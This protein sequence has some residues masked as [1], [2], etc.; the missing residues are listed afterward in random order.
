MS[1]K[2]SVVPVLP[3]VEP[4]LA[5]SDADI[6]DFLSWLDRNGEAKLH[7]QVAAVLDAQF[8]AHRIDHAALAAAS[9]G[10]AGSLEHLVTIMLTDAGLA[11]KKPMLMRK[12]QA[13][14][15]SVPDVAHV[16]EE[17]HGLVSTATTPFAAQLNAIEALALPGANGEAARLLLKAVLSRNDGTHT[18]MTAWSTDRLIDTSI[19]FLGALLLCRKAAAL[20]LP[21]TGSVAPGP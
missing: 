12:L 7:V 18:G 19:M 14:W 8:G 1:F 21:A 3:S 20:H 2:H 13:L 15:A 16:L 6:E 17:K 9:E 5:I 4:A 10:L 11:P